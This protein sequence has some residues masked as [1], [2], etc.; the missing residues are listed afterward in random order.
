LRASSRTI[1]WHEHGVDVT[2][3]AGSIVGQGHGGAAYNE[4][5]CDDNPAGKALAKRGESSLDLCRTERHPGRS[6]GLQI[7]GRQVNA[8]LA[9]CRR[10][11]DQRVGSLGFQLCREPGPLK[12]AYLG[13]F[14]CGQIVLGR[15]VLRQRCQKRIPPLIASGRRLVMQ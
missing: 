11:P 3:H 8:M 5:I 10:G 14:R 15:Q 13:P 9:E 6:R 4:Y 2:G 12:H 7:P 1:P